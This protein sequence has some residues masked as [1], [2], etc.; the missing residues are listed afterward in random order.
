MSAP[1]HRLL[2]FYSNRSDA[3]DT[4]TIRLQD[5]LRGNLALGLDF[6]AALGLAIGRHMWLRNTSFF[7]LN[8]HVPSVSVKQTLLD[9]IAID[10]K[11]EYT[12]AEI[13]AAARS[14]G[15]MGQADALGLWALASDVRSGMLKGEDIVGFQ[16]GT[17]LGRIERRRKDRSQVLPFYRGGPIS[18]TGHSWFVNKLFGVDVYQDGMKED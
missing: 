3:P 7:S 15:V 14:N 10:E 16:R 9:G 4:Q 5:S 12:R 13:V 6:P 2:A 1:F 17:L 8:I 11:K 18:V